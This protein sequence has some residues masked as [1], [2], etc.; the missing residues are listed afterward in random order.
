M[1]LFSYYKHSCNILFCHI[2]DPPDIDEGPFIPQPSTVISED[3]TVDIGSPVYV[4]DGFDVT[5]DC[6]ILT[7]TRPIT[8]SWFRNG[9]PDPS[10]GNVSTITVTDYSD[11]DR[12]TCR[13]DNNIG[14]DIEM[15]TINVFSKLILNVTCNMTHR[16]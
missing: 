16:N 11:G 7:G 13:A 15:T 12:F 8:I 10:R 14:F 2:G 3:K 4:V 5:I 6:R 9:M 1:R